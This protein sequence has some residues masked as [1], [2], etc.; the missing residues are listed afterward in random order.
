MYSIIPE[1]IKKI[2]RIYI[3]INLMSFIDQVEI[4]CKKEIAKSKAL[5]FE[6]LFSE[7]LGYLKSAW[8]KYNNEHA[9]Y[10][11]RFST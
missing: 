7:A 6:G 5:I 4:N 8:K 11:F 2:E 3:F 10:K 1:L 9:E